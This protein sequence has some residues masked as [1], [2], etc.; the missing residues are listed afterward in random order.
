MKAKEDADSAPPPAENLRREAE[1]RLGENKAAPAEAVAEVDVRALLHELQ[2]HQIELQMQNEE[3]QTA[4]AVAQEA[5]EKYYELFDFAPVGYFLWDHEARI[6]EVNLAGAGLLGLT[7]KALLHKRFGQFVAREDRPAFSAFCTRVLASDTQQSCEVKLLSEAGPVHLL[8]EGIVAADRPEQGKLCCAAV[9]DITQQKRADELAAANQALQAEIAAR[10]QA[11][12]ALGASKER[13]QTLA[14]ATFEGVCISQQG[15]IRDCNQQLARMLGYRR[16]EM[17]AMPIADLLPPECRERVL[18]NIRQGRDSITEHEVLHKDGGRRVVEAHGRNLGGEESSL[19]ITSMRD[20]TQHKQAEESLQKHV[21]VAEAANAAKSQ[22][23]A[24][25]SHELRTPMNAILGMIDLALTKA[26][27]P[28]V[29]D[30]LQT[31]K[32]SADLLLALLNDLLDTAKV[33]SGKMETGIG[34]L[35]PAADVG[36]DYPRPFPAGQRERAALLL[37]CGGGDAGPVRGRPPEIPASPAQS[38]RKRHQVHGA[39]RRGDQ[40]AAI[41]ER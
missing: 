8:V 20:V 16:E 14:E 24:N 33:E 37:P 2:V 38:G 40:R 19:R 26:L 9:I 34:P 23:L 35:Q 17:I 36:A 31:A 32:G 12:E 39:R 18:E 30:C 7:R 10:K 13:Y 1:R 21:R 22:F 28:T 3:L 27:D 29:Q 11:E 41:S 6:L 4:Q 25:M 5:A 15:L